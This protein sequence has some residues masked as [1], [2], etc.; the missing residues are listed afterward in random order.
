MFAPMVKYV[1]DREIPANRGVEDFT[2]RGLL[3]VIRSIETYDPHTGSTLE[4]FAWLHIRAAVLDELRRHQPAP[5]PT[6]DITPA[7]SEDH[8]FSDV[9]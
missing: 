7:E 8:R 4:Q 5:R 2:T 6:R 3:A 9:A 1:V